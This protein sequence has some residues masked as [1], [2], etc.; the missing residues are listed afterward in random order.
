[1]YFWEWGYL[2]VYSVYLKFSLVI[3]N[4]NKQFVPFY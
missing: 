2:L 3:G 1:M 4:T